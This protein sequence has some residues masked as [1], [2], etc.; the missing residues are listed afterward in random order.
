MITSGWSRRGGDDEISA[1]SVRLRRTIDPN[2][3]IVA[4]WDSESG[5]DVEFL[6]RKLRGVKGIRINAEI[7]QGTVFLF[8]IEP[9]ITTNDNRMR[10]SRRHLGK[11][12]SKTT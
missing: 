8:L 3:K 9:P 11:T 4:S 5:C 10:D 1:L 7:Y 6:K 12:H 2:K